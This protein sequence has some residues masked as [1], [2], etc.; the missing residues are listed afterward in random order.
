MFDEAVACVEGDKWILTM[1]KKM[2]Q[3]QN[4]G[5]CDLVG[6]LRDKSIVGYK[7]IFKN[8]I[9]KTSGGSVSIEALASRFGDSASCEETTS[10]SNSRMGGKVSTLRGTFDGSAFVEH[11]YQ[12]KNI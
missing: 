8:K 5:T 4:N 10:M 1:H 7:Q 11:L 9:S 12:E 2:E 6:P 3:L